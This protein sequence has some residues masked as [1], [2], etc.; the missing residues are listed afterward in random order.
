M[1][2]NII[3]LR[4]ML[5]E[6]PT[7]INKWPNNSY[8]LNNTCFCF[9]S[10]RQKHTA[11]YNKITSHCLLQTHNK[12]RVQSILI[13]TTAHWA[14]GPTVHGEE[15]AVM[16]KH[17]CFTFLENELGWNEEEKKWQ[18]AKFLCSA[19]Q[20]NPISHNNSL[21]RQQILTSISLQWDFYNQEKLQSIYFN[22]R[23]KIY[24]LTV[25]VT[26][27]R[28]GP[29]GVQINGLFHNLVYGCGV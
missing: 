19:L 16:S 18:R 21:K 15:W 10:A 29:H 13:F 2:M 17:D 4:K 3:D 11:T 25:L 27:P 20:F 9:N 8:K 26:L 24:L 5:L 7:E 12:Q 6:K 28:V 14:A 23:L 1:C 22:L